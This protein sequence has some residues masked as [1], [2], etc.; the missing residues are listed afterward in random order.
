MEIVDLG[1][2]SNSNKESFQKKLGNTSV[3]CPSFGRGAP[4]STTQGVI[5]TTLPLATFQLFIFI[6]IEEYRWREQVIP[7]R[8]MV[9]SL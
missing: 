1:V 3:L 4:K 7:H 2:L 6:C 5:L 8:M 9:A